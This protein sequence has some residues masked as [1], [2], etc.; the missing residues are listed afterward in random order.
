M[1]DTQVITKTTKPIDVINGVMGNIT[2]N[3]SIATK[4]KNS[5]NDFISNTDLFSKETDTNKLDTYSKLIET[6]TGNLIYMLKPCADNTLSDSDKCNLQICEYN[7]EIQLI[8]I[9]MITHL[10]QICTGSKKQYEFLPFLLTNTLGSVIASNPLNKHKDN[11]Y[12][13]CNGP[14]TDPPNPNS[15][16]YTQFENLVDDAKTLQENRDTRIQTNDIIK[17]LGW[18]ALII[19]IIIII[20]II[21]NSNKKPVDQT[22]KETVKTVGGFLKKLF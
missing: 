22:V 12:Y 21:Y 17:Y 16:T 18:S 13:L 3:D 2:K 19:V 1:A 14:A 5:V 9:Y 15:P 4:I 11:Q 6:S 20:I 8:I 7:N 10:S